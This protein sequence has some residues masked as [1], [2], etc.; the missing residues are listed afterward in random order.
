MINQAPEIVSQSKIE[1]ADYNTLK[2]ILLGVIGVAAG[3]F[4]VYEFDQ[5]LLTF[6]YAFLWFSLFG[7]L[8]FLAINILLV[9]FV[10]H[11]IITW[12]I[13]LVEAFSPVIFFISRFQ[14]Q[15]VRIL[16]AGFVLLFIFLMLGISGGVSRFR[17]SM[18]M[19][20]FEITKVVTPKL[21][22]GLLVLAAAIFYSEFFIWGSVNEGMIRGMFDASLKSAEPIVHLWYTDISSDQTVKEFFATLTKT[23]LKKNPNVTINGVQINVRE[24][25]KDLPIETQA[26]V[27]STLSS[28]LQKKFEEK[29][30]PLD[31][32]AKISDILYNYVKDWLLKL[33]SGVRF[34]LGIILTILL[35]FV[36]KGIAYLLYW[37]INLFAFLVFK[38]LI[39]SNFAVIEYESRTRE[40]TILP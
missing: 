26:K 5:F 36:I 27:M 22:T 30:G 7:T 34:V 37:L 40:F 12:G 39:V 38:L 35:F 28:E 29:I 18:K 24:G 2:I 4:A 21:V 9:F 16:M 25:L 8:A 20:F 33:S 13:V 14:G 32:N 23:Q 17:N 19:K 15:N 10:K 31:Q 3:I 1:E 11:L 6:Q